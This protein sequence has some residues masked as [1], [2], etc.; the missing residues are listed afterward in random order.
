MLITLKES[1]FFRKIKFAKE[2]NRISLNLSTL[3]DKKVIDNHICTQAKYEDYESKINDVI[4][5]LKESW[6]V[7]YKNNKM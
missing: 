3:K 7:E 5:T 2:L 1:L 6:K 4:S